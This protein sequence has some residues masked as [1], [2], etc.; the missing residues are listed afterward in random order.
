[1]LAK[2]NIIHKCLEDEALNSLDIIHGKSKGYITLA[3]KNGDSFSQYHYTYDGLKNMYSESIKG[4]DNVYI[5][6]NTFYKP[7]RRIENL[8]EL[9]AIFIDIDCYNKN[10]TKEAVIYFLENDLYGK[11]PEAS[12]II[13]SGRGLYYILLIEPVP[14]KA[15]PLWYAVERYI[16][17]HLKEFGAD[18]KALDPAR[19]LRITGS[20]NS[21]NNCTVK[22]IDYTENIYTLKDIQENY[23]PELKVNKKINKKGRPKKVVSLFNQYSLYYARINDLSK[24]CELRGYDLK[25]YRETLL[26]LYRYFTCCFTQDEIQAL[27]KSIELNNNF[28]L[29]LKE[30]EVIKATRSAEIAY[31]TAKYKFT[32]NRLI[33]L[34]D[35]T[36]EEQKYLKTIISK[37]EANEREKIAKKKAR[38]N[39]E[40]LTKREEQKNKTT[41]LVQ[42]CK[43]DGLSQSKTAKKLAI[44]I[45]TVKRHW[46]L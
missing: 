28:I 43:N 13:D 17:N 12:M 23:L 30:N 29:P 10:Y 14:A 27:E 16:Y 19:V 37:K 20:I 7:Q 44:G 39:E 40:G 45:A 35:I 21:K 42:K 31:K 4:K 3:S 33:E 36:E 9:N 5:S 32:N 11:I 18:A 38:R 46:N 15:L 26:F 8:K 25:G 6:Q 2:K 34:L 22:I 1:M 41:E 24:I